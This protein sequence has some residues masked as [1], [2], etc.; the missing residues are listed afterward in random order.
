[1]RPMNIV[2]NALYV[3]EDAGHA[4]EVELGVIYVDGEE[5]TPAEAIGAALSIRS[6]QTDI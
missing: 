3:L 5:V 2:E 1:M 4:V 6:M